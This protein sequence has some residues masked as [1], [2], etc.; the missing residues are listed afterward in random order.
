MQWCVTNNKTN[1]KQTERTII[2][3]ATI[4]LGMKNNIVTSQYNIMSVQ[5]L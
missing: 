5:V 4:E 2:C 3:T 1:N